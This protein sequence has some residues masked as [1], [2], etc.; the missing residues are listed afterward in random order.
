MGS[1][2]VVIS[3]PELIEEVRKV[4]DDKLSIAA[5]FDEVRAGALQY[6]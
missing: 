6:L 1:W 4:P 3:K 2:H 5:A